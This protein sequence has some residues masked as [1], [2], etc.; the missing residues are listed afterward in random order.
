MRELSGKKAIVTGASKGIGFA[1]ASTLLSA[2][3]D[4]LI[5]ARGQK[6]IDAALERLTAS[7]SGRKAIGRVADVSKSG[8]VAGL[9]RFADQE[10]GGLDILINNAGFGTFRA[11]AEL[12]VEDWD[13]LIGTNLSGAFYCSREALQRFQNSKGGSIINISSLAGKNPFAGGAAYNASKFGLNGFSEAMMLDHRH[14]NVRVSYIMPGSVSTEFG[15]GGGAR[16][17]DWMIAP[18]DIAEIVLSILRMPA[19]TLISRVEVRPSRPRKD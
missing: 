2:G 6:Q 1:I 9:F 16:K 11:T 4:V 17:S 18:E 12:T 8:D 5:C 10:L 14:D 19:R 7:A 3:A 15:A 13:R